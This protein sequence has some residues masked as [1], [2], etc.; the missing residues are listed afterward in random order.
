MFKF[1][2]GSTLETRRIQETKELAE[3]LR[4]KGVAIE[5]TDTADWDDRRKW[6]FYLNELR[7]ISAMF[8]KKLRGVLR[9]H[10]AGATYYSSVPVTE[11]NFFANKE[12]NKKLKEQAVQ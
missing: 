12:A 9:T 10:K 7:P 1:L 8:H 4:E 6:N 11:D 5:T 3:K 2:Y